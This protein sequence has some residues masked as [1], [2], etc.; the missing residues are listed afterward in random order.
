M[1]ASILTVASPTSSLN[2][3][4]GPVLITVMI[5][6]LAMLGEGARVQLSF[7]RTGLESGQMWRLLTAHFVHLGHYHAL[8]NMLGLLALL[9]LCPQALSFFEW[10]RR[11]LLLS[12]T[13][14]AALYF[15]SPQITSYVGFSGVIHGLFLLGLVPMVRSRDLI[16]CACLLY[17]LGKIAWESYAGAPLSDELAIGGRVVTQSHL[18]GTLAGLIYGLIFGSFRKEQGVSES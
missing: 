10:M 6:L 4:S 13:T 5:L 1:R 17:L 7:E 3:W 11:I 12:L 18:F 15:L 14:S 16:A 8:L 9:V 2:R